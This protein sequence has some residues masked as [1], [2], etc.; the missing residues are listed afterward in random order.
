MPDTA[1]LRAEDLSAG[2]A[3]TPV[4]DS[5]T[6]AIPDGGLTAIVGP[7]AC[8]KSTLLRTLARLQPAGR[9]QAVLDGKAIHRQSSRSV[10][11]RLAILPQTPAAPEG[12]TVRD[13]VARGR[14][15]YQSAL[16]QWS[17]QD[18]AAV[19]RALELTNMAG[20]ARR[21]LEALSGGQR[22]RA[23]IAMALAQET[24]ILLLDEPTTYLDLPHQIELLKLVQRLNR[25]TGRT[26]AMVLHDINLAAR[27]ASHMI[28]LKDGKVF[29]QGA[30]SEV[31]TEA[32]LHSVF[33]LPCRIIPDPLHGTPHV[34]PA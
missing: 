33:Q 9:G 11:R 19:A 15:P 26:V 31:V 17:R 34:I 12:L 27:F 7:N 4:L 22:Q 30:P 8:G 13:L 32:V 28:A 2:Y 21:P 18:A 16:R 14:T 20:H 25:E 5:L 23:W 10:A 1:R 3:G 29:C 6:A 24:G